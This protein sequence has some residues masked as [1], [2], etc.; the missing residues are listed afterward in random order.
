TDYA[1]NGTESTGM[2]KTAFHEFSHIMTQTKALPEEFSLITANAYLG[3]D[4][5]TVG[6][7]AIAAWEAGFPTKYARHSPGEDFAEIT[8][9]YITRGSENWDALITHAGETGAGILNIKVEMINKYLKTSW[10]TS[11]EE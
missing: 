3:D 10:G 9:V 1:G 5:S 4:W 8:A 11:L 6:T 2:L 7:T